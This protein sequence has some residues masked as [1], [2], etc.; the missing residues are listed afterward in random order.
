MIQ[1]GEWQLRRK[2]ERN[3]SLLH[4]Q[5]K[6]RNP[7]NPDDPEVGKPVWVETGNYFQSFKHA[8]KFA[9][10]REMKERH[11]DERLVL[12]LREAIADSERIAKEFA[13]T[14]GRAL[15]ETASESGEP[16]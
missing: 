13:E 6:G 2:D 14:I 16:S 8:F 12:D 5:L 11:R 1:F 4:R 3:W 7:K 15:A 10:E 9:L